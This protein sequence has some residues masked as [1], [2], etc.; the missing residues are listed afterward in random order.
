M[1]MSAIRQLRER[2]HV[3]RERKKRLN[4]ARHAHHGTGDPGSFIGGT[5]N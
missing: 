3:R 5:G 4:A 1:L 2:W